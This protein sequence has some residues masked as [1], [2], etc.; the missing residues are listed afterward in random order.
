MC[1][2]WLASEAVRKGLAV[3]RIVCDSFVEALFVNL[4]QSIKGQRMP[5][6]RSVMA[7]K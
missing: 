3:H 6:G 1:G 2:M 7:G 5:D 4:K